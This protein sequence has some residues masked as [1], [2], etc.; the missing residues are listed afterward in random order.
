MAHRTC[1]HT[2]QGVSWTGVTE[3]ATGGK[4]SCG[5]TVRCRAVRGRELLGHAPSMSD[6]RWG[7]HASPSR[8]WQMS[9]GVS[10]WVVRPRLCA[11]SIALSVGAQAG[12]MGRPCPH[13]LNKARSTVSTFTKPVGGPSWHQP[14]L[15]PTTGAHGA[16]LDGPLGAWPSGMAQSVLLRLARLDAGLWTECVTGS[17]NNARSRGVARY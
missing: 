8:H 13:V 6:E 10:R 17:A 2:R 11:C 14:G 16:G 12:T 5:G 7:A 4:R 3:R 15:P 9:R 1:E